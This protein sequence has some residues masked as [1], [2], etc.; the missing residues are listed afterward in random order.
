MYPALHSICA[1]LIL[2]T[3][4]WGANQYND[5]EDPPFDYHTRAKRDAFTL[6]RQQVDAGQLQLPG[7]SP[8]K[9]FTGL[10][11]ALKIP[12]ESQMLVFSKT[13]FQRRVISADNCRA[14]YFNDDTYLTYIPDGRIEVASTDPELGSVFAI[15]DPTGGPGLPKIESPRQCLGCHAGSFTNF[16]PGPMLRSVVADQQGRVVRDLPEN[17]SGHSMKYGERWGAWV[18]Q[19]APPDFPHLGNI[20][21]RRDQPDVQ[22]F[23]TSERISTFCKEKE[24]PAQGSDVVAL[25]VLDHQIAAHNRIMSAGY[26][27]RHAVDRMQ[28]S[29]RERN[30]PVTDVLSGEALEQAREWTLDLLHY[31][32]FGDEQ[33][34]P[35]AIQFASS[36]FANAFAQN[37]KKAPTG[38]SLREF[39]LS[40]RLFKHRLSYMVECNLLPAW[41]KAYRDLF[42]NELKNGLSGSSP[43]EALKHLTAEEKPALLALIRATQANLPDGF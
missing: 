2:S 11:H 33:P 34:L 21:A 40:K 7:G 28:A 9:F 29:Q 5:F 41:P 13:S 23:F 35:T 1:C 42:W 14:V 10:L 32:T 12:A 31:L 24:L 30:Q 18:V 4:C 26:Q 16:L 17:N 15:F 22:D 27:W 39:D 43:P 20:L 8:A 37:A 3:A 38:H 25:L 6:L 36:P 19:G